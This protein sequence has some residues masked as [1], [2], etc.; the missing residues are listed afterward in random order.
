MIS[1]TFIRAGSF[2][3]SRYSYGV[4]K[5]SLVIPPLSGGAEINKTKRMLNTLLTIGAA[6]AAFKCK[7]GLVDYPQSWPTPSLLL[8]MAAPER[9]A[10][11]AKGLGKETQRIVCQPRIAHR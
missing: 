6:R 10:L 9:R 5:S 4:I 11:G 3:P 2:K 7:Q 1:A 8:K